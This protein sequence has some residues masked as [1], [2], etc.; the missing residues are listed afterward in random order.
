MKI[1]YMLDVL[2]EY[3]TKT[4]EEVLAKS[5]D[6]PRLFE[7]LVMR[8]EEAFLRKAKHIL[9]SSEA[10]Q[11]VVQDTFVKIYMYGRNFKPVEGARFTSWAYRILINTCFLWYKKNKRDR[12][13]S[14][15]IDEEL[16][17]VL[18]H[19]DKDERAHMLDR[20]YLESLFAEL[21]ETFARI[22]RLYVIDNNDYGE[23]AAIEKVS[24]GAIKTRM[25]RAR[26]MMKELTKK[27]K[28]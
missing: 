12:E 11:D 2:S 7:L 20:D 4:D 19:D 8:H 25:H 18:P 21:P 28:Y 17:A 10:A 26:E 1:S 3:R 13:F 5:Y 23:I 22:L 9:K 6:V 15:L 16:E 27:I 14:T 24:E